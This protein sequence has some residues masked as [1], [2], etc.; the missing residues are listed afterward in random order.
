L[1]D[2]VNVLKIDVQGAELDVL[3]GGSL[4]FA[5]ELVDLLYL[6]VIVSSTYEGQASIGAISS[7][8]EERFYRLY[9]IDHLERVAGRLMQFDATFVSSSF[10]QRLGL[11]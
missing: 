5:S 7:F 9:D 1:I 4:L 2:R 10:A 6:E 3:R 8:L 11:V